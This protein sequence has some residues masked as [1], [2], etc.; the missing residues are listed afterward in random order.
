MRRLPLTKAVAVGGLYASTVIASAQGV[1]IIDGNLLK[2]NLSILTEQESDLGRQQGK[3][4][5][6][7]AQ[8]QLDAEIIAE[9]DK[10]ID[11]GSLPAEN[12]A[13]M[14]QTLEDGAGQPAASVEN[15]YNPQDKNPA[16]DKTFGD[17]ALTVEEVIIAGAKATYSHAGVSQAGLSQAQW[18]AL[19]QAMIWQESRFNPFIGSHAGAWGLTQL[20]PGTAKEVGVAGDYRTNP[21]SQ[22]L[23]GATYLARM[24]S[25]F[26]GNI[27]LSLAAYN[28][29]PGNVQKYGGV[30]PFKETQHYVQVIPAKYNEYLA[31]IGGVDALGTIEA[32]DA[33]GANLAMMGD[34]S[35]AYGGNTAQEIA[36]IA[37]RLKAI[38]SQMEQ[39]QNPSQAWALNTYARAEMGRIMVLRVRVLAAQNKT[40]S[41]EAL[42]Q[43]T[44]H[45]EERKYMTFS[46][47]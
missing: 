38:I 18:R 17:A 20:M 37:H 24:L 8:L 15:L 3:L 22:V 39:N 19:L 46:N 47:D 5:R 16:A 45:A 42:Q 26:D 12:T 43:A 27:V 33:A 44:A 32:V 6:A 13:D 29:G 34:G 14:V 23:G 36:A 9:L 41:A 35:S 40:V 31:A 2:Q 10:L 25:M 30:P 21:Y 11:A 28:A 7:E 4:S 1:P